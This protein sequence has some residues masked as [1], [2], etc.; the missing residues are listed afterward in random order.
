MTTYVFFLVRYWA[1]GMHLKQP[2]HQ[3]VDVTAANE[4]NARKSIRRTH[5][6]WAIRFVRQNELHYT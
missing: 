4:A 1:Y 5:P 6:D 2:L 3:R